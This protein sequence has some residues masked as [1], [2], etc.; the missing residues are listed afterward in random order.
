[1]TKA[2]YS[3]HARSTG[4]RRSLTLWPVQLPENYMVIKVYHDR[5]YDI[6]RFPFFSIIFIIIF[7]IA[8]DRSG[9]TMISRQMS[10]LTLSISCGAIKHYFPYNRHRVKKLLQRKKNTR[11]QANGRAVWRLRM[12]IVF[13]VVLVFKFQLYA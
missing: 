4:P 9:G 5:V 11:S 7:F 2:E 12:T 6:M 13:L 10:D 8:I 1:M 3:E